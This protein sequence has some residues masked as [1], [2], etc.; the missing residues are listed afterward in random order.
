CHNSPDFACQ[1]NTNFKRDTEAVVLH[2]AAFRCPRDYKFILQ[3]RETR[4][5]EYPHCGQS[6]KS[7][8]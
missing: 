5:S 8:G 1:G 7:S 3:N 2:N 4:D 6:V